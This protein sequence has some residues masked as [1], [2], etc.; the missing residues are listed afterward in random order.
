MDSPERASPLWLRRLA[1]ATALA[2]FGL[3][4]I[5]GLVTSKGAGMAVPDWP[6]TYGYNMFFFPISQWTGGIFYE[7]SHRL[8]ASIVGLLTA[9]TTGWIWAR[10][11]RGAARWIGLV[12]ILLTLGLMG[13][14][15]QW[16]FV[17]LACVALGVVV[18]SIARAVKAERPLR[19]WA[20]AAFAAVLVQGVLGGL[21]VTALK[22]ELGIVHGTFAQ[23]FLVLVWAIAL[24]LTQWWNRITQGGGAAGLARFRRVFLCLAL[25][26]LAQLILGASMRHQHAGLAISDFPLAHGKLWPATDAASLDAYNRA[27]LDVIEAHP[28]TAAHIHLHMTH[29]VT[30]VLLLG[31]A[32]WLVARTQRAFGGA[33]PVSRFALAWCGL[34]VA[35]AAFGTF[36]VLSNKAAD[37]ATLHVVLGALTLLSMALAAVLATRARASLISASSPRPA[38][39]PHPGPFPLREGEIA[40]PSR[41]VRTP[42]AGH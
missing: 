4:A 39:L 29:R 5:G 7:H 10:E 20:M 32:V 23:L 41:V 30:A 35:Q 21:R 22:D 16:M 33:H 38:V 25:L 36:T 40:S 28:I 8:W 2:T 42:L 9:V 17:A 31:A 34:V 13:V 14:R 24:A 19:W 6:T 12:G 37:I 18:F 26:V 3:I 15:K 1:F 27:R 11:S